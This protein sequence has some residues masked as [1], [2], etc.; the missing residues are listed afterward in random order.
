MSGAVEHRLTE[1]GLLLPL[2]SHALGAYLPAV[3]VGDLVFTSGQLPLVDGTL[4]ATGIV[5]IDVDP[6]FAKTCAE[7]CA[8]NA[9]RAASSVCDLDDIVRV[10]KLTG[11]VACAPGFITQPGVVDGASAVMTVAF[12]DAGRHAREAIGVAALPLG[13]PVEVSVIMQVRG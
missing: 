11:F 7:R 5:G 1:A 9:L 4:L 3:R 6:D 13:S 10:V 12:G 8:L 2:A